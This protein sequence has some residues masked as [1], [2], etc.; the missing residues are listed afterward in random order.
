MGQYLKYKYMIISGIENI[1]AQK[2]FK[3]LFLARRQ[4]NQGQPD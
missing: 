3:G 4:R 1:K 2:I